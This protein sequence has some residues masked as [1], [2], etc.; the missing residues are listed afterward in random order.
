[1][2]MKVTHSLRGNRVVV[3]TLLVCLVLAVFAGT[4]FAGGEK[5]QKAGKKGT[6]ALSF[7]GLD[8]PMIGE[9]YEVAKQLLTRAGYE[10]I[11]HDPHWDANVQRND[12]DTWIS[13]RQV[14]MIAYLI[15]TDPQ[16]WQAVARKAKAAGVKLVSTNMTLVPDVVN[17]MFEDDHRL[18]FDTGKAM[19]DWM[20]KRFKGAPRKVMVSMSENPM[21]RNR[22]QGVIDALKQ[23]YPAAQVIEYTWG[24][25]TATYNEVSNILTANPDCKILFNASEVA[26]AAYSAMLDAGISPTDPDAGIFHLNIDNSIIPLYEN[27]D[28]ILRY[29]STLHAVDW[30]LAIASLAINA[31]ENGPAIPYYATKLPVPHNGAWDQWLGGGFPEGKKRR[32]APTN[33]KV[34]TVKDGKWVNPNSKGDWPYL[35]DPNIPKDLWGMVPEPWRA[36]LR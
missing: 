2:E 21:F 12:W 17:F 30:A 24:D 27:P 6:V 32:A 20:Q 11:G 22:G 18:G 35:Q 31:M 7:P 23:F 5:E 19:A 4:A 1:M 16:Q 36:T 3:L 28:S 10:V 8:V 25:H 13:A 33:L 9:T 29:A 34:C 14:D 15:V 26:F